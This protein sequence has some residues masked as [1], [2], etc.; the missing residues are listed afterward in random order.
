MVVLD[1]CAIIEL[2]KDTSE[3]S[4]KA[5]KLMEEKTVVLSVSFAE[6]LCKVKIKK[7]KIELSPKALFKALLEIDAVELVN[8]GIEEW[9]DSIELE[10]PINKDPA[11]RLITAFAIK[12]DLFIVSSDKKIKDFYKKVIW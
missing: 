10:W 5:L 3:L 1:T 4:K 8:I 9:S 7:L 6:I 11:D 2:F 12:H